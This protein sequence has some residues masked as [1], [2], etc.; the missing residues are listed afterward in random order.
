MEI[1]Q[2]IKLY[3]LEKNAKPYSCH[4]AGIIRLVKVGGG[5]GG[6]RDF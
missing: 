2:K 6:G 4:Y 1:R 5:G 3:L